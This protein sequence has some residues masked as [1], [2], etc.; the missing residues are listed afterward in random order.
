MLKLEKN[1]KIR[2]IHFEESIKLY[3]K[4]T[5]YIRE[6]KKRLS[7]DFTH[8]AKEYFSA[9]GISLKGRSFIYPVFFAKNSKVSVFEHL[10]NKRTIKK[11]GLSLKTK[12]IGISLA[13]KKV[14]K[15]FLLNEAGNISFIPRSLYEEKLFHIGKN[16][17]FEYFKISL[18]CR[19]NKLFL[20]NIASK[21]S[22]TL[23]FKKGLNQIFDGRTKYKFGSGKNILKNSVR[24]FCFR[25]R[26][27]LRAKI[28]KKII[29]A[30]V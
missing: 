7:F 16:I 2:N 20:N 18:T 17:F 1:K 10:F 29:M 13:F 11:K 22:L 5:L 25:E 8:N 27:K 19:E 9:E 3:G 4:K 23:E 30:V 6:E 26:S 28:K 14:K 15:G 21:T 12:Y 24:I